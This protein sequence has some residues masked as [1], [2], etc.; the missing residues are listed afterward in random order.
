[1]PAW[2]QNSTITGTEQITKTERPRGE[3]AVASSEIWDLELKSFEAHRKTSPSAV[4]AP[5]VIFTGL[6]V[7]SK[8]DCMESMPT[9]GFQS[10]TELSHGH[11]VG[12]SIQADRAHV[13]LVNVSGTGRTAAKIGASSFLGCLRASSS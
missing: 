4:W 2:P 8:A 1:M 6:H 12:E 9:G 10:F 13:F 5:R 3:R 7:L 11:G